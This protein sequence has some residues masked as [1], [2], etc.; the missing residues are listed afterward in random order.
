M[1]GAAEEREGFAA[2]VE[3][4]QEMVFRTLARLLGD[5]GDLEDLGQEVFLRL[6]RSLAHFRGEAQVSTFLYRIIVNVVNDEFRRRQQARRTVSLDDDEAGWADS[7]PQPGHDPGRAL[8]RDRFL[9][10]LHASL[11]LLSVRERAI[12][13]LY[14]QEERSYQEICDILELPMGTVKTHLHRARQKLKA[15]MQERISAC[16][17]AP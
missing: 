11:K 6:F 3:R 14:Y 12:L 16:Q 13:T 5:A 9:A 8:D 1:S 15:A 17:T 7:L 4:H 2:L 10:S